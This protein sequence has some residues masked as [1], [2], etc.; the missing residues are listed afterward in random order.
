[1][2][3]SGITAGAS[4]YTFLVDVSSYPCGS[5]RDCLPLMPQ[6]ILLQYCKYL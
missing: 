1:V 2:V 3:S 5:L 4:A 6:V